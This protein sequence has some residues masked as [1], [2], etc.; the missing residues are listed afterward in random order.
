MIEDHSVD[1]P[2]TA[3]RHRRDHQKLL[4]VVSALAVLHQH[5][6]TKRTMDIA[7][8]PV[9]YLEAGAEDVELGR[10]LAAHVLRAGA[11]GLSPQAR[12]LLEVA[13]AETAER[14][15][16]LG[17]PSSS[18]CLTRRELRELLGWSERQVRQATETLLAHEHLV[19]SGG[20]RGRLRS[21]RVVGPSQTIDRG[22]EAMDV[23]FAAVR[24]PGRRTSQVLPPGQTARF[25]GS[26]GSPARMLR[27]GEFVDTDT[28]LSMDQAAP[29]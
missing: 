24:H 15:E 16:H 26:P 14:A 1:F 21:Y 9:T 10:E 27:T 7:G 23:R 29:S 6:R 19:V 12:R 2:T 13:E 22:P 3:T 28:Y 25:A 17:V 20:G 5:Q 18:V 11:E 8:M 4:S